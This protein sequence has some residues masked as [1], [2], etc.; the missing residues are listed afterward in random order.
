MCNIEKEKN[1]CH[2]NTEI[3][4]VSSAAIRSKSNFDNILK[5]V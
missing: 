4:L 5:L 3:G 1:T 2:Y